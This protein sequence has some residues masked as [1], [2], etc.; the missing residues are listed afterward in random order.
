LCTF[1]ADQIPALRNEVLA[2]QRGNHARSWE[3]QKQIDQP[4][5]AIRADETFDLGKVQLKVMIAQAVPDAGPRQRDLV[6]GLGQFLRVIGAVDHRIVPDLAQPGLEQ[7][8]N[9]LRILG[10]VLVPRVVHRLAGAGQRQSRNQPEREALTMKKVRQRTVIV[11]GCLE[12][13]HSRR[14]ES[15]QLVRQS[16]EIFQ[17]IGQPEVSPAGGRSRFDQ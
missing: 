11:A 9:D 8:Q 2:A 15:A 5:A 1:A 10:I 13:D 14:I 7:V 6:V 12:S 4:V 17:T 16:F 3:A